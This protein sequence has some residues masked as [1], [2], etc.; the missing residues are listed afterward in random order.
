MQKTKCHCNELLFKGYE[1]K[2][3]CKTYEFLNF[4]LDAIL[5]DVDHV[6]DGFGVCVVGAIM[7][8]VFK[9]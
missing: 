5:G 6:G 1:T 2:G 7:P 3:A 8:K 4:K 9:S